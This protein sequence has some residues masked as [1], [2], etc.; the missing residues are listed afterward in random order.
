[1]VVLQ[2]V[3]QK[4]NCMYLLSRGSGYPVLFIHG[5]PTSGQLWSGVIDKLLGRFT[6]MAVDLPGLGR[7][8]RGHRE[9]GCSISQL[10]EIAGQIEKIR[11]EHGIDK[12]HVVGH[13]AGSAVAVHYAYRFQDRVDRLALLSPAVFP[14]L[15]PFHLFRIIRRPVIGELLAPAVSAIFWNIAMRYATEKHRA[16]LDDV[17]EDFHAPFAGPLGAWRLMS[18]LRFGDPAEILASIPSMLPQLLIPTLIFQ[19]SR[20]AAIPEMFARRASALI[21]R[22][23]VIMVDSG[24]FIPLNNPEVVAAELLNFFGGDGA[25]FEGSGAA[26]WDANLATAS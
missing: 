16:G 14:E 26:N 15:K 23:K 10:E 4:G 25:A 17:V 8:P 3:Q 6:C 19:G 1:V 2:K 18:V 22:S 24:H 9:E 11:V 12:W 21:P 5:I 13:D 7:T 20:D